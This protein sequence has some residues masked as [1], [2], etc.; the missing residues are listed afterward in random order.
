MST[1]TNVLITGVARGIGLSLLEAYLSRPEHTVIGTVRSTNSP[2]TASL[3]ALPTA[4]NTRLILLSIESTFASD[5]PAAVATLREQGITHL[6]LVIAN[7]G[8]CPDPTPLVNLDVKDVSNAFVVNTVGPILLFQAVRELLE[9]K[10]PGA[11]WVSMSTGAASLSNLVVHQA[12]GVAA[13][14]ISKGGMNWFT[15]AVHASEQWLTAF[16]VHPGYV[17]SITYPT[18]H[19]MPASQL[20]QTE[21]GNKGAQMMGLEEAPN[22]LEESTSKT[23][24]LDQSSRDDTAIFS[25]QDCRFIVPDTV[26]AKRIKVTKFHRDNL[27]LRAKRNIGDKRLVIGSLEKDPVTLITKRPRTVLNRV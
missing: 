20:V 12:H 2:S 4:P 19:F 26:Q 7:A 11:K 23:I 6:D 18:S 3:T 9:K 21:M 25:A 24:A 13:Y 5:Y 15:L 14:G 27:D 10:G 16:A 1:T 8:I 17:T 22:T